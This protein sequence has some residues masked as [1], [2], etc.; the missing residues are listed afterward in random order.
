M[1]SI[2]SSS[3][4]ILLLLSNV[5]LFKSKGVAHTLQ[6]ANNLQRSLSSTSSNLD[7]PSTPPSGRESIL[8]NRL[9]SSFYQPSTS[10]PI[11]G[12]SAIMPSST[13]SIENP[14]TS[15]QEYCKKN[16]MPVDIKTEICQS[17]TQ[18]SNPTQL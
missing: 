1:S 12:A 13:T 6:H 9:P 8:S 14:I 10:T 11:S 5:E 2:P 16:M 4:S 7:E 15:L 18:I 17:T 3:Q